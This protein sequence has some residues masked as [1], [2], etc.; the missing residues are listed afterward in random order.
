MGR[1]RLPWC[2]AWEG[3][4]EKDAAAAGSNRRRS[5]EEGEAAAFRDGKGRIGTGR[6]TG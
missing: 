1:R 4:Q 2:L 3:D 6:V 5:D